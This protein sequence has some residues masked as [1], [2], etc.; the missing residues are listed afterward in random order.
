MAV[1][2]AILSDGSYFT[3]WF[4]SIVGAIVALMI[5]SIPRQIVLN[6]ENLTIKC[7]LEIAQIPLEEIVSVSRVE[8]QDRKWVLPIFGSFGF[9]GYFG[10]FVDWRTLEKVTIYATEWQNMIE[11]VNIY[12]DRYYISCR[13]IDQFIAHIDSYFERSEEV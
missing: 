3:A 9:F 10:Y 6:E 11:I 7:V 5:L 2:I 1:S 4:I 8:P 12:D 13:D